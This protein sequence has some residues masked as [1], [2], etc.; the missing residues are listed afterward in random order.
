MAWL[1]SMRTVRRQQPG[2][3]S[4]LGSWDFPGGSLVTMR[5]EA[6][7]PVGGPGQ[8]VLASVHAGVKALGPRVS[9]G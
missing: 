2:E 1:S 7:L 8:S 5:H 9:P 6:N 3:S 4:M